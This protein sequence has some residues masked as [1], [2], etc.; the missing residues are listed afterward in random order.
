[1]S[2]TYGTPYPVAQAEASERA[3]FIRR[4]YAHLA[5]AILALIGLETLLFT[6]GIAE[7]I[8]RTIFGFGG[9]SWLLI[10]GGFMVVSW[11]ATNFASSPNSQG[12]QYLGLALYTAAWAVLFVPILWMARQMTGDNELI[13]KAGFCTG[14]VFVGLT[15]IAFFT[16]AD[17][18]FFRSFLM[19][20]GFVALG[21]IIAGAIFG[22]S[23]GIWF[24][25]AMVL[26][27]SISILY[28]TSNIIHHYHT[29]QHVAAALSLFGSIAM[30]FWYILRIFMARD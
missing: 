22:F 29:G 18:S 12:M 5:A 11:M 6:S 19:I 28:N 21:A 7:T 9:M 13:L 8:A 17:F 4:T 20:G 14:A 26:F 16:R 25:A 24:S 2:T 23:L 3:S 27:A 10:L 1:M 15:M 30:L